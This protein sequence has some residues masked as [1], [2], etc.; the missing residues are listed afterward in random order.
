MVLFACALIIIEE[1]S[2]GAMF[3]WAVVNTFAV[4]EVNNHITGAFDV[5]IVILRITFAFT[6]IFVQNS[7]LGALFVTLV[8]VISASAN[9]FIQV[10]SWGTDSDFTLF[11]IVRVVVVILTFA[12]INNE[13][14]ARGAVMDIATRIEIRF[15]IIISARTN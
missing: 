6:S 12:N 3:N 14:R 4:L 8:V 2:R 7:T 11:L 10:G 1:C 13:I 15:E 9:F 5:T